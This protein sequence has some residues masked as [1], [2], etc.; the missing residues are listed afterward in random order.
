MHGTG[1][2]VELVGTIQR[3]AGDAAGHFKADI[4]EFHVGQSHV[5]A[6]LQS[7]TIQNKCKFDF[8]CVILIRFPDITACETNC[9]VIFLLFIINNLQRIHE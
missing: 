8:K 5:V 3:E 9:E 7:M 4:F 1:K 2:A 6:A